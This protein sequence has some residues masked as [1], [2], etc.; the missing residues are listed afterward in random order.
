MFI[1]PVHETL[2]ASTMTIQSLAVGMFA[3][4]ELFEGVS[5]Y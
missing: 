5:L 1:S 4:M 3:T 2:D